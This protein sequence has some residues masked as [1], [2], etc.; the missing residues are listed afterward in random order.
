MRRCRYGLS[1]KASYDLCFVFQFGHQGGDV[2]Y[3]D[4]G[5]ALGRLADLEGLD[6][7][8]HVDTEVFGLEDVELFLLGLMMLGRVT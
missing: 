3:L 7:G 5:A 2:G 1:R 8:C 4:A 6:A